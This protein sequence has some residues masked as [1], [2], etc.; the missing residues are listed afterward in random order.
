MKCPSALFAV[1]P[2]TDRASRRGCG[3][4]RKCQIGYER[5]QSHLGGS[6]EIVGIVT[7]SLRSNRG[8]TTRT[9]DRCRRCVCERGAG[10]GR[11]RHRSRGQGHGSAIGMGDARLLTVALV[12]TLV[13]N[14]VSEI[15][16]ARGRSGPLG[17][18]RPA[19][20]AFAD[21]GEQQLI[22]SENPTNGSARELGETWD[23]ASIK[24]EGPAYR[25][26]AP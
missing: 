3:D 26:S 20:S 7:L 4:R 6:C 25:P 22:C 1:R 24:R 8:V 16:R 14:T 2:T 18:S 5:R 17:L 10:V 13:H 9:I 11:Y 21:V 23:L 12:V 19:S 15:A